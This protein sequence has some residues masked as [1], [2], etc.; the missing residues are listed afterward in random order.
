MDV[1][2][3]GLHLI[4]VQIVIFLKIQVSAKIVLKTKPPTMTKIFQTWKYEKVSLRGT[5]S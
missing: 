3:Q 4:F 2:F 5:F 1:G